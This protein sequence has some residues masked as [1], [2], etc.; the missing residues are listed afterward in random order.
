[1][2]EVWIFTDGA[3][4]GNPGPGGY[5]VLLVAGVHRKEL[6]GGF[7]KTTNN[8]MELMAAISGLEQL[9]KP[10]RVILIS[11]SRYLVNA[12]TRDWVGKWKRLGWRRGPRKRLRNEDLWK[13][14]DA[15]RENHEVEWRWIRGHAGHSEN[16][17]CDFLAVQAAG[18]PGRIV[19]AGYLREEALDGGDAELI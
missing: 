15:A 3:C 8:R 2:K 16:E 13:R 5:G 18:G 12:M 14:L 1:M 9:R 6:S 10:C 7:D 19:D 17:R 4:R 11:D